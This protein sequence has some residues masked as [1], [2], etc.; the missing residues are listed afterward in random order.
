MHNC[1]LFM[2]LQFSLL[3][4][5]L[6]SVLGTA[7]IVV[8]A[9]SAVTR[10]VTVVVASN[11]EATIFNYLGFGIGCGYSSSNSSSNS[12]SVPFVLIRATFYGG[13]NGRLNEIH[14]KT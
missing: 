10:D 1:L 12:S 14:C 11:A 5:S 7:I 13:I 2:I 4:M 9:V 6:V 8:A 3:G